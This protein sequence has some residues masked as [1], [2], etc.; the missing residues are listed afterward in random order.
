MKRFYFLVVPFVAIFLI[1]CTSIFEG[2]KA[3]ATKANFANDFL[4]CRGV[5]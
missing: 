4:E 1:A 2:T 5:S 3:G